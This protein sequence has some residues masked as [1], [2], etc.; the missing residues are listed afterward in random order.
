ML[1]MT[2]DLCFL[3]AEIMDLE[4]LG[5]IIKSSGNNVEK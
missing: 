4:Q 1:A 3:W 2:D 5:F